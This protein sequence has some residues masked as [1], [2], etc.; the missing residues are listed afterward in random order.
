MI[1]IL[2]V[3][4][5]P[6][7][8]NGLKRMLYPMQRNW[9]MW[10][11]NSGEE[12]LSVLQEHDIEV[13]V[14]DMRMPRMDGA[15]LLTEVKNK[16]PH[17]IRIILS[18]Y[19]E[20]EMVMKSVGTAH[21]YLSKPCDAELLKSTIERVCS[22]RDILNND[23]LRGLVAQ[24][25]N[26]PSLPDLYTALVTELN[27]SEPSTQK[28][29]EIIKKDIGMT[30]K[31]LQI[32]NSAFFGLSRRVSDPKE[33]IEYLGLDTISS[34]TLGLGVISQ[35]ESQQ[36]SSLQF[37]D[38]WAHSTS[39]GVIANKI[40]RSVD[41]QIAT[42]AFTA[43]LLHDVGQVVL[44]ANLPQ[45]FGLVKKLITEEK[46]SR[47]EAERQ[48]FK[49][50][51]SEVGAYLLGLWG[52]PKS[53][54]QAVEFHHAPGELP[55]DS[56]TVLTAV[57][58]ADAINRYMHSGGPGKAEPVFDQEYLTKL[59]LVDKIPAWLEKYSNLDESEN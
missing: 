36:T 56:F 52:L 9:Q 41:S 29:V 7:I 2:F 37:A 48:I 44:A 38:I 28:V 31:I 34:L 20:K 19:S 47:I 46:I 5:E 18:G 51:H 21:Q 15:Q 23:V 57:H 25:P 16:Y 53:V 49:A 59:G 30:V 10:F 32:V 35:F 42:D 33:A 24:M 12:S 1:N 11:A 8:L 39:V 17:I 22:L 45:E 40:A 13:V 50:T 58:A 14:S 6:K 26:V 3:D 4:D 55:D 43:G 54:V 27:K